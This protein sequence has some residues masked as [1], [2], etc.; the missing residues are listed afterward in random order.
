MQPHAGGPTLTCLYSTAPD[1]IGRTIRVTDR[2]D[3]AK[4]VRLSAPAAGF[5]MYA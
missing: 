1:E 4:V 2:G 5:V 3:G